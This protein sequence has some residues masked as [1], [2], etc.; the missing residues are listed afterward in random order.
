MLLKWRF[1]VLV[2]RILRDAESNSARYS[3]CLATSTPSPLRPTPHRARCLTWLVIDHYSLFF[4]RESS[5]SRPRCAGPGLST[6]HDQHIQISPSEG[7]YYRARKQ[8]QNSTDGLNT[9]DK[10]AFI[11]SSKYL[12]HFQNAR[13]E[14]IRTQRISRYRQ[15]APSVPGPS[16][17]PAHAL[18]PG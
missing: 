4:H 14:S 13:L 6:M 12:L 8:E 7:R 10:I 2:I 17:A 3:H 9:A 11:A 15:A 18:L 1:A 16:F 5:R